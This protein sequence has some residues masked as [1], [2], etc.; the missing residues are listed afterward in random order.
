MSRERQISDRTRQTKKR[1]AS[2]II[3]A[4]EGQETEKIYLDDLA[5]YFDNT[6]V[7]VRVITK[8]TNSNPRAR[9]A[10][11]NEFKKTY[12]AGPIDQLWLVIDR[13]RWS[14][15]EIAD[16]HTLC[17]QKRYQ[18]A[19]S[20]PCFELWLLLHLKDWAEYTEFEINSMAENK[21]VSN[22][23]TWLKAELSRL[24]NGFSVSSYDTKKLLPQVI[25]AIDRARA[26]DQNTA[27]RQKLH[28][29]VYLLIE[30]IL[31]VM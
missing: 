6:K 13:D 15:E 9:L 11:L 10:E 20:T 30:Q 3:I 16:V 5:R 27:L 17:R 24:L 22:E 29:Q 14:A 4:T 7:K 21:H 2:L 26:L 25:T 8:G 31:P 12:K 23:K 1:D 28:T 18:I 19:M